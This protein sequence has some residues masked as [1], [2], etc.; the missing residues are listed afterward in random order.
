[1]SQ[2]DLP[3][4]FR[5]IFVYLYYALCMAFVVVVAFGATY[6]AFSSSTLSPQKIDSAK[7]PSRLPYSD[8]RTRLIALRQSLTQEAVRSYQDLLAGQPNAQWPSFASDW[9]A[10]LEDLRNKC[11]FAEKSKKATFKR[12][13][14]ALGHYKVAIDLSF[15]SFGGRGQKAI[16][17]LNAL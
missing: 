2:R 8:C 1:M 14:K 13:V 15:T 11:I 5:S 16:E 3:K 6:G 12:Q 10:S 17:K 9:R 7:R 4:L